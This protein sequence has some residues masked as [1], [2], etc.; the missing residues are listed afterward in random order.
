MAELLP[1]VIFLAMHKG[2]SSFLAND[3]ADAIDHEVAGLESMNIGNQIND[4]KRTY[5]ELV[6]PVA[7]RAVVRVYP[8]EYDQLVEASPGPNGRLSNA[9]LVAL[10]RDP[11]DAAISRYFSSAFSHSPPKNNPESFLARREEL[12]EM[13]PHAGIL[14]V[15]LATMKEFEHFHRIIDQRTDALLTSYETMVTDYRGWLS[16]VGGH[17]GWTTAEQEAVF[18]RSK[19]SLEF[20]VIGNPNVH[21]RRITPGNW[22]RY[23]RPNLREK[24]D[25]LGGGLM[26]KSGYSWPASTG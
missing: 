8:S 4:Q 25:E 21:V 24:F 1:S 7:G 6:V 14:R 13:G 2:G 17:I 12:V 20:P 11:R 18:A 9:K 16:D 22:L 23:D 3:L 15:A 10:Q 26:T 19:S 5:E